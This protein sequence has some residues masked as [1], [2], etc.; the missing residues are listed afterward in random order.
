MSKAN[1][2]ERTVCDINSDRIEVLERKIDVINDKFTAMEVKLNK[3]ETALARYAM[4][5]YERC[6]NYVDEDAA[7]DN[8]DNKLNAMEARLDKLETGL[9]LLA[10]HCGI[11]G[12][13]DIDNLL[14]RAAADSNSNKPK[15]K[16]DS[17][18]KRKVRKPV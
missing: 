10:M 16:T 9:E 7:L 11:Y 12:D 15:P 14:G 13:D 6:L 8:V 3:I 4:Y 18:G 1:N 2:M 5:G 17:N